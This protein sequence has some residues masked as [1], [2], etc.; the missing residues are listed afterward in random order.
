MASESSAYRRVVELV[1]AALDLDTA[2]RSTFLDQECA[3]DRALRAEVDSLLEQVHLE[4][5]FLEVPAV[6][7]A[8]ELMAS[9]KQP[10]GSTPD[11]E[12]LE[13][14]PDFVG[15]YRVLEE[16]GR[17]GMGT[18]YLAE[19]REPIERRVAL[20]VIHGFEGEQGSRRFAA[21]C[22]ALA[23][24]KHP[25]IA[26]VYDA[27]VT[28]GGRAFVA[29]EWVEGSHITEW[30]DRNQL[31]IRARIELFLGVCAAVG[32]AHQ[33]GLVHRDLKPSNVLVAEVDGT[34]T[35]K[36]ID[37]GIARSLDEADAVAAGESDVSEEMGLGAGLGQSLSLLMGSPLYMSPEAAR[38][39]D[40]SDVD[41]RTDVYSLGILLYELLV[42]V[43]PHD[44]SGL[45]IGALLHRARTQDPPVMSRRWADL[46]S[47]RREELAGLRSDSP[48]ALQ[49]RLRGDL[50]AILEK[51]TARDRESRYGS[52]SDLAA[53]LQ[54]A[55]Q[56]RPVEARASSLGYDLS[57]FVR[58]NMGVIAAVAIVI[59]ALT[60]GV[61][62][63]TQEARR[64]NLEADR[65][66]QE[67]ERAREAL[68]E[69]EQVSGFLIGLF[70]VVDPDRGEEDP[71]SVDELLAKAEASMAEELADL[72]LA[73]ARFMQTIGRIAMTRMDLDRAATL[74]EQALDLREHHGPPDDPELITNVGSL[75]V[76]YRRQGRL[77][78]A[79]GMLVRAVELNES[80]SE[81]EPGKLSASITWLANLYYS[82]RRYD[83]AIAGHR[84][85]LEIRRH[86][87]SENLGALA[88]SLNNLGVALRDIGRYGEARPILQEAEVLFTQAF[89][90][91]HP[92]VVG[93]WLNLAGIEEQLGRWQEAE[94]LLLRAGETWLE[95]HGPV[96]TRTLLARRGLGALWRRWHRSDEAVAHLRD[97]LGVQ[98]AQ[99]GDD[100]LEIARTLIELGRAHAQKGDL[101][102]A[103][104]VFQQAL[105][106]Y[107]A[108]YGAEHTFADRI[109]AFLVLVERDRGK[110]SEA[111]D[112]FEHLT[113]ETLQKRGEGHPLSGWMFSQLG[114]IRAQ[115]GR[116][117]EAETALL[118]AETIYEALYDSPSVAAARNLL[119]LGRL[120][121]LQGRKQEGSDLLQQALEILEVVLP[122]EHP[123]LAAA[124]TEASEAA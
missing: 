122:A 102:E 114:A 64:A 74:Y 110:V 109:R 22:Q 11:G 21:E 112:S 41:T 40:R 45:G 72:P 26:A 15:P 24:L 36:V 103:E 30:C 50:D 2:E 115:Q 9:E 89:G 32:H 37:F 70:E 63:R 44:V 42:G 121:V 99:A 48:S 17:G 100:Q 10:V 69:A 104:R 13:T 58:R 116:L 90:P 108:R 87:E 52:V 14:R 38:L 33:K 119:Q 43:P 66:N 59:A 1:D 107:S 79:E 118:Q 56:N 123:E 51:A 98:R 49:R 25:N 31:T 71:Q 68:A 6:L 88:E 77:D 78:E 84:R 120:R 23:R 3:D 29:M 105:E 93:C 12:P 54:R 117:D 111:A 35:A 85:A 20:K 80:V 113:A 4:D 53:D 65:A 76:I 86:E 101:D 62:A 19:Q 96:H 124:R 5:D 60:A 47:R 82:Q 27:G 8:V 95:L 97:L 73:R 16:L 67:A 18:V 91:E 61:V 46:D 7:Q 39:S 92:W 94:S 75:G 34:A 83:E 81:R 28:D 106:I 57:R 55:Q